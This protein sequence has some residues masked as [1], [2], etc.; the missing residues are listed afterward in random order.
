M[1]QGRSSH[2][3][4]QDK[5]GTETRQ[6]TAAVVAEQQWRFLRIGPDLH[7]VLP[8]QARRLR[9]ER[10][11][12]FFTA[13]PGEL[14]AGRWRQMEVGRLQGDDFLDAGTRVEQQRQ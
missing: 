6:G 10:T 5:A 12:A 8:Q 14:H 1:A 13:F 4:L 7:Q 3:A 9:P 11:D 2:V